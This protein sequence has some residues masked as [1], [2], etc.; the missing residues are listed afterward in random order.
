M[1]LKECLADAVRTR[2][3]RRAGQYSD[4]LRW[5]GIGYQDQLSACEAA[6]ISPADFEEAMQETDHA[7]S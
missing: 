5:N 4:M 6:G 1:T 3:F 7:E 2:D